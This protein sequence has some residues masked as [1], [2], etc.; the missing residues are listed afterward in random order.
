MSES[1]LQLVSATTSPIVVFIV[2]AALA[3]TVLAIVTFV[4]AIVLFLRKGVC[5]MMAGYFA[6]CA[7]LCILGT[8]LCVLIDPRA[9]VTNYVGK[10][11]TG[12]VATI[13]THETAL[14]T[15]VEGFEITLDAYPDDPTVIVDDCE[16]D[17][18]PEAGD[19]I[20]FTYKPGREPFDGEQVHVVLTNWWDAE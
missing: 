18:M 16:F 12:T 3:I 11:P 15:E 17:E 19:R 10:E 13:E 4:S 8:I 2:S 7:L 20:T 5:G 1:Y 6:I 9:A 14:D